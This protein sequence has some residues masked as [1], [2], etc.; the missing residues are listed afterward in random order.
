MSFDGQLE[1]QFA[2]FRLRDFR[3]KQN[4]L[5][6][7]DCTAR[8]LRAARVFLNSYPPTAMSIRLR[9]IGS[10]SDAPR[11]L[12]FTRSGTPRFCFSV[13]VGGLRKRTYRVTAYGSAARFSE[14]HLRSDDRVQIEGAYLRRSRIVEGDVR[15]DTIR[16]IGAS[17]PPTTQAST[18]RVVPPR[19]AHG[20]TEH[21]RSLPDAQHEEA[22]SASDAEF[23]EALAALML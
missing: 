6:T 13:R 16:H 21:S 19:P 20:V 7:E 8:R 17:V 18:P 15:A 9:F 2:P 14:R 23:D 3:L 11:S 10:V 5:A 12:T 22:R 1:L 4:H